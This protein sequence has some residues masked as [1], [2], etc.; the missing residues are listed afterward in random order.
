M[1]RALPHVR[2][3][4]S[5]YRPKDNGCFKSSIGVYIGLSGE[6]REENDP[7]VEK[8]RPMVDIVQVMFHPALHLLE[9]VGVATLAVDLSPAGDAWLDVVAAGK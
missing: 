5:P 7:Q 1:V 6:G 4:A 3:F 2:C 9:R 8:K